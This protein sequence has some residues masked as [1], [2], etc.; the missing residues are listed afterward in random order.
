MQQ[1]PSPKSLKVCA[2]FNG[3]FSVFFDEFVHFF[4]QSVKDMFI[5]TYTGVVLPE[6]RTGVAWGLGCHLLANPLAVAVISTTAVRR[7]RHQR[8]DSCVWVCVQL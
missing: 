3:C 2:I 5:H 6:V 4:S 7:G 8:M 1:Q